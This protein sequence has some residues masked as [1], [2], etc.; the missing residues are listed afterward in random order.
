MKH[1]RQNAMTYIQDEIPPLMGQLS[2]RCLPGRHVHKLIY[3]NLS[4]RLKVMRGRRKE[5]GRQ[6]ADQEGMV[7]D[8]A[9]DGYVPR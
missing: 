8:V 6:D 7:V 1:R 4:Q 9:M 2:A 5:K 3:P